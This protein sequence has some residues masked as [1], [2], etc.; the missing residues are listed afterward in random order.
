MEPKLE[1]L[2]AGAE[3]VRWET[4][5]ARE[6]VDREKWGD[7]PWTAE[8][9]RVEWRRPGS[10]L[11]RLVLRG[12]HG[13]WCGYVGLPPGHPEHGRKAWGT[14]D[15]EKSERLDSLDVHGG[16]TYTNE[17][18]GSICHVPREGESEHVWWIGFD[19][20]HSGDLS[21]GIECLINREGAFGRSLLNGVYR[22]VAYVIANT[23]E[24]ARQLEA[25]A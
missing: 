8:P 21:P 2:P 7:G 9:D 5:T 16:V 12:P 24:L 14:G 15:G 10:A 20:A 22:D 4:E 11:P 3:L 1:V 23:E 25:I 6:G 17:C 13:S 18:A 19:C